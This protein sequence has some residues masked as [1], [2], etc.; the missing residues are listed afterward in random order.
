MEVT[1]QNLTVEGLLRVLWESCDEGYNETWNCSTE[2]GR[3]GFLDMQ[4]LIEEVAD[5]LEI[6]PFPYIKSTK[7]GSK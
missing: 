3:E 7:N 6:R 5:R 1:K 2:E 4:A